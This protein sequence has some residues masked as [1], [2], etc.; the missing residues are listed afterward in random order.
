MDSLGSLGRDVAAERQV[1]VQGKLSKQRLVWNWLVI[2]IGVVVALSGTS[3][4]VKA[5]LASTSAA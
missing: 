1:L 2:A 5:L 4:S 3:A